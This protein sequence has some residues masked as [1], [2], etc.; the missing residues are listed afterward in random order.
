MK[1]HAHTLVDTRTEWQI[2][3]GDSDAHPGVGSL[4]IEGL[5]KTIPSPDLFALLMTALVGIRT[6]QQLQLPYPISPELV[7]PLKQLFKHSF[8][9]GPIGEK[10]VS[11]RGRQVTAVLIRDE[12]DVLWA[13]SV[14]DDDV[15]RVAVG[16]DA[17]ALG[18]ISTNHALIT[19]AGMIARRLDSASSIG[20]LAAIVAMAPVYDIAHLIAFTTREEFGGVDGE[21]FGRAASLAGVH[22]VTPFSVMSADQ[23]IGLAQAC[24]LPVLPLYRS[25]FRRALAGRGVTGA[26]IGPLLA[27]LVPM[28][29]AVPSVA[30]GLARFPSPATGPGAAV[31][32][33]ATRAM[34]L[35]CWDNAALPQSVRDAA[36]ASM[37]FLL[38]GGRA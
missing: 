11:A 16:H 26:A 12:I 33:E 18:R 14:F 27:P 3:P 25:A 2:E 36:R 8:E 15:V 29:P 22:V 37:T 35:K 38:G 7:A 19:N 23:A 9:I 10:P 13:E 24:G 31:D 17:L 28:A 4:W 5:I 32:L 1:V 6:P 20:E 21:K 34:A 30:A